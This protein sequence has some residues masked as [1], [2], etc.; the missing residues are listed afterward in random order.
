V[1]AKKLEDVPLEGS[2]AILGL[3]IQWQNMQALSRNPE[4]RATNGVW[5]K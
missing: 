3:A 4:P 2:F 5:G 1:L